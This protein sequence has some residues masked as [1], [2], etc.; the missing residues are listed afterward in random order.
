MTVNTETEI[1]NIINGTLIIDQE[2]PVSSVV[3]SVDPQSCTGLYVAVSVLHELGV[4]V[5]DRL[6]VI[7]ALFFLTSFRIIQSIIS[8][9]PFLRHLLLG[10]IFDIHLR[11]CRKK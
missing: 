4:Q 6:F 7:S 10:A 2:K 8:E 5:L 11:K 1:Q 3:G 9:R